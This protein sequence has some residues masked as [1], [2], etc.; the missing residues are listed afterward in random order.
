MS[1]SYMITNRQDVNGTSRDD[2]NPLTGGELWFYL[3]DAGPN[4]TNVADFSLTPDA[5]GQPS[6]SP[7]DDFLADLLADLNA[8]VT[9]DTAQLVIFIHGL[10]NSFASGV[11]DTGTIG[12]GL[13]QAGFGGLVIGFSWPSYGLFDSVVDY[14]DVRENIDGSLESFASL[15]EMV[16]TLRAGLDGGASL[17][18]SVICHSEGNYMLMQGMSYLHDNPLSDWQNIDNVLMLAADINDAALQVPDEQDENVGT[19]AAIA[20]LSDQVTIYYSITDPELALSFAIYA[21]YHN[22]DYPG[23]LGMEGPFSFEQGTL[24]T[25]TYGVDCNWV[26]NPA[27]IAWLKLKEIIPWYVLE[28]SSYIYIPQILAD[29][30]QTINGTAPCDVVNRES[31]D[32]PDGQSYEME[33]DDDDSVEFQAAVRLK[34][35]TL[36]P[37]PRSSS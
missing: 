13:A 32:E 9:N 26:V 30:T 19:G 20:Q 15:L 17:D 31:L 36:L 3:S 14:G 37:L 28:H 18:L 29:M 23:R 35:A 12:A 10:A 34:N 1:N 8:T 11:D 25:N 22:P 6:V 33:V 5:E 7:P 21:E 2:T 27:N 16:Q 4:D 24:E